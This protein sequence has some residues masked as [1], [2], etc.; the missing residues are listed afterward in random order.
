MDVKNNIFA[1][2]KYSIFI[3][4]LTKGVQNLLDLW[5]LELKANQPKYHHGRWW[6]YLMKPATR[7]F[8][9]QFHFSLL[10]EVNPTKENGRVVWFLSL[11]LFFF[12]RSA[13][14]RWR[15]CNL[16]LDSVETVWPPS[17]SGG[18]WLI[19]HCF[20]GFKWN[21][22]NPWQIWLNPTHR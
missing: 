14:I 13:P 7:Q 6:F 12:L 8:E 1:L 19:Y 5:P 3:C 9:S 21:W 4:V 15:L 18:G 16:H 11:S 22:L 2:F 17:R 10:V 20:L